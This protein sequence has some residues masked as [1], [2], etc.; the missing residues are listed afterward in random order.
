MKSAWIV[1]PTGSP[2]GGET[3]G[4]GGA[5]KRELRNASHGAWRDEPGEVNR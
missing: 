4:G 3:V 5:R 1:K 2:R